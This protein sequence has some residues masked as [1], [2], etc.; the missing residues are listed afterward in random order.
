MVK[1][2]V[3]LCNPPTTPDVTVDRE[4]AYGMGAWLDAEAE[5]RAPFTLALCAAT[6]EWSGWLVSG[7]DAV[8]QQLDE[9]ACL[10]RIAEQEPAVLVL[11]SSPTTAQADLDFVRYVRAHLP[12]QR[13]LLVGLATRYLPHTLVQEADMVL[14]GEP[15]AAIE[16]ACR[17]LLVQGLR[18][19]ERSPEMLHVAGYDGRGHILNLDTLP[20]PA[21]EHF[22]LERYSRLP[23]EAGRGCTH[24]CRYCAVPVTHGK[25]LRVRAPE[26]VAAEMEHLHSRFAVERFHFRDPLFAAE[27][28]HAE[29]LCAA[30]VQRDLGDRIYW[31]C[32]TRPEQLD[33]R[34]LQRMKQAG[35]DEIHL[36]LESVSPETLIAVGRL[37]DAH[38][39]QSYLT[40]VREIVLGCRAFEIACHLYVISGLPGS[41]GAAA[42]TRTFLRA[43]SSQPVHVSPLIPYPGTSIFPTNQLDPET[44]LLGEIEL[45]D[46]PAQTEPYR[47][48]ATMNQPDPVPSI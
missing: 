28:E 27:R 39:V 18:V 17:Y 9:S 1:S 12:A 19:G 10:A 23:I 36:G 43:Y 42:V 30:F 22:R 8:E 26:A 14:V 13:I 25:G 16:A 2:L 47:L 45:L 32:E 29:K 31:S 33:L 34:L 6:L 4:A 20:P 5:A 37:P 48:W 46:E 21:W 41:R 35:C 3:L 24:G 11:L 44:L 38:A 40:R 15:E 7:L